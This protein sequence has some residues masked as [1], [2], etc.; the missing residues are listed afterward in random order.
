MELILK[1][2][3]SVLA[4]FACRP[5]DV[6]EVVVPPGKSVHESWLQVIQRTKEFGVL[7]ST[8][9]SRDPAGLG[10]KVGGRSVDTESMRMGSA[11]ARVRPKQSQSAEQLFQDARTRAGGR[12]LWLAL[13]G[14]QDPQN[15]GALFR[16]AA[17]FGVQGIVLTQDRSAALTS[18]VYDVASGGIESVPFV[19]QTNLQ[20]AFEIAKGLG[21]WILGTSENSRESYAQITQ[22]RPWLLVL[23]NEEKGIR[24]LTEES[25]D[26]LCG[27]PSLG[28]VK[29]LNVSVAG[30]VLMAHLKAQVY[31]G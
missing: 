23:G 19:L 31:Q 30:G 11:Y 27:I 24:R 2:P 8:R 18:T 14:L 29:S 12:G 28:Q 26:V 4:V 15:V 17:F 7:M 13:D 10:S 22:D 16:T 6:L 3:H 9:S 21:L 1:N 25:C 20:R 5:A